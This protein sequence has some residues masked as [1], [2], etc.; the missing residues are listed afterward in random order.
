MKLIIDTSTFGS[1][2]RRA[3]RIALLGA[4]FAAGYLLAT[5][6]QPTAQAQYDDL[7]KKA[8]EAAGKS[9]GPLGSA[10]ELGSSIVDM[11]EHVTALNANLDKLEKIKAALG[12]G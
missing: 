8:L 9:G 7:G 6:T 11:R 3:A 10:A 4:V 12:G 2:V 5:V 1:G